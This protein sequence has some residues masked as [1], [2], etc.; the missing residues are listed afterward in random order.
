MADLSADGR[1]LSDEE[2][3]AGLAAS[4]DHWARHGFG[5]WLFRDRTD[6]RFVGRGGLKKCLVDG[7]EAVELAYAVNRPL[8]CHGYATEMAALGLEVGFERLGLEEIVGFTLPR[9][10]ASRRVMEKVGMSYERDIVHAGL[11][12]A[13]YRVRRPRR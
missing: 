11:P 7:M 12:H 4:E 8:M 6:G 1:L 3:R 9:N 10:R 5:L 13:L 2:T